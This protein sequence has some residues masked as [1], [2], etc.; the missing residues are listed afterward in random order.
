M[1]KKEKNHFLLFLYHWIRP[2][3]N[4]FEFIYSFF[5]YPG[6][7]KNLIVYSKMKEAEKVNLLDTQPCLHDKT[8]TTGFDSHYFYQNIWAARKIYDSKTEHHTDIGSRIDFVGLLTSFTEVNFI[9][10]RPL[11]TKLEKFQSIKGDILRLPFEDN[12]IYSLSCLHVAEHI[13]LGRYGDKLDPLGTQKACGELSRVL[14]KNGNLYFALPVGEPRVCFNGMR[15]HSPEKIIKYFAN[16][17]LKELSGIDDLG[18]FIKNI[19][20]NI[21][22]DS[23]YACGLFW[24]KKE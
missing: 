22:K 13:G 5:R 10:I 17:K 14:A 9:D 24:F 6:Y 12:S 18:N 3:L 2:F 21:L 19:D 11:E 8:S 16:L 4:P 23:N 7:L 15:V 1:I 20:I